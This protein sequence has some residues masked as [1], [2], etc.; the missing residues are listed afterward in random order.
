MN[1]ADASANMYLC[2]SL[3]CRI[4]DASANTRAGLIKASSGGHG[5]IAHGPSARLRCTSGVTKC[6]KRQ[7]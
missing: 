3:L 7:Q 2:F 4:S 5:S 6:T 1:V